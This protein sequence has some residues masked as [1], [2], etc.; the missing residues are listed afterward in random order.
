MLVVTQDNSIRYLRLDPLPLGK[1]RDVPR[2]PPDDYM[3][4][5]TPLR[6]W[7]TGWLQDLPRRLP[8][9]RHEQDDHQLLPS[10][11]QRRYRVHQS[12]DG[13]DYCRG[14]QRTMNRFGRAMNRLGR[15]PSVHRERL[16]QLRQRHHR[17]S[18]NEVHIGHL[19]HLPLTVF[20]LPNVAGH[21][22][23]DRGQLSCCDLA[24]GHQSTSLSHRPRTL[25]RH[26]LEHRAP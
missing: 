24:T 20:D 1:S 17:A 15:A 12:C 14:G 10:Q 4:R 16:K 18:S 8:M 11:Y 21:Q 3:P 19:P 26:R 2:V 25:R 7:P 13:P 22:N 5:N 9:P 6:Q 23:L